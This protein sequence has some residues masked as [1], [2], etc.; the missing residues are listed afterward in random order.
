MRGHSRS[1]HSGRLKHERTS[2]LLSVPGGRLVINSQFADGLYGLQLAGRQ[3]ASEPRTSAAPLPMEPVMNSLLL[4]SSPAPL[5]A[6]VENFKLRSRKPSPLTSSNL[7]L[8]LVGAT[9]P[10]G[11]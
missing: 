10:P 9:P 2:L 1:N 3:I 7:S 8:G 11:N 6:G 4:P 5:R